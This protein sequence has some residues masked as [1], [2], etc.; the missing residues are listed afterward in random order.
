MALRVQLDHSALVAACRRYGVRRL[1]VFGSAIT[2]RFNPETSDLD[3]LVDFEPNRPD[4]LGDYLGLQAELARLAGRKVDLVTTE[5]LRN[6]FRIKS[7][8]ANIED[9]Y[10]A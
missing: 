8:F 5:S 6:P 1:R 10:A 9:V 2:D 3:V 4:R 7:I